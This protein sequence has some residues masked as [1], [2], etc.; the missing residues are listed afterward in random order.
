[1]PIK[2]EHGV[3]HNL[4]WAVKR[5]GPPAIDMVEFRSVFT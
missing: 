3:D 5:N 2:L 1:M 4:S